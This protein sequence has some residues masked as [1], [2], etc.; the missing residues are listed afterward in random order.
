[1]TPTTFIIQAAIQVPCFAIFAILAW[2]LGRLGI[3]KLFE[4]GKL[5]IAKLFEADKERT[6]VVATGFRDIVAELRGHGE[7]IG[8]IETHLEIGPNERDDDDEL[9]FTPPIPFP[10]SVK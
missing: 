9:T 1:M 2:K 3:A 7:R 8:R 4:I 10:F 6:Q 5:G